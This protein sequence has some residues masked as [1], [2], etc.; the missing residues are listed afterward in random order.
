MTQLRAEVTLS[1]CILVMAAAAC[2]GSATVDG[3][4]G[5]GGGAVECTL[6]GPGETFTFTITNVGTRQLYVALGCGR[7]LPIELSTP[8]GTQGIGEGSGDG[9]EVNCA[10][11]YDGY[12]NWGCS[13]CGS[14]YSDPL[15]PGQT[16]TIAWDRRVYESH[17][18]PSECSG[19]EEGN[20]CALGR[21]LD[22]GT[23]FPATLT[24]CEYIYG[25]VN[26]GNDMMGYCEPEIETQVS[27]Q[28]D[29]SQDQA[30]IEVE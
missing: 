19:N 30:V 24:V 9:C 5:S 20:F 29:L 3:T 12:E 16:A 21:L 13:D 11:V 6:D 27:F 17:V 10:N 15:A 18:A 7:S 1:L 25:D 8:A 28:V 4:G 14:G 26:E 23:S 22:A 2:D